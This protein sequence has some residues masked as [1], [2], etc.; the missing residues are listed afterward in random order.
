MGAYSLEE[1]IGDGECRINNPP[2]KKID[3]TPK[4]SVHL[5]NPCQY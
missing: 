5:N 4:E 3:V 1:F 2:A